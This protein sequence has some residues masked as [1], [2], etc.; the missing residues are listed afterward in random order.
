MNWSIAQIPP[1]CVTYH[2]IYELKLL[3]STSMVIPLKKVKQAYNLCANFSCLDSFSEAWTAK[4]FRWISS[5]LD[6]VVLP[7]LSQVLNII[8]VKPRANEHRLSPNIIEHF[9]WNII[10]RYVG[11]AR[12]RQNHFDLW[13]FHFNERLNLN[14]I[15]CP[16]EIA[17]TSLMN[18]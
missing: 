7:T 5:P 16:W 14:C 17:H 9:C 4:R 13:R 8:K 3:Q 18:R 12:T 10:V 6:T 11:C 2:V 15:L 1:N